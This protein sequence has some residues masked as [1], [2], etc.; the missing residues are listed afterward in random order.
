MEQ[1]RDSRTAVCAEH[2]S[3]S[4]A[5][6]ISGAVVTNE[7]HVAS[8]QVE[9]SIVSRSDVLGPLVSHGSHDQHT[10]D[11]PAGSI[12]PHPTGVTETIVVEDGVNQ[13]GS[14]DDPPLSGGTAP[15]PRAGAGNL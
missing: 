6:C 1:Q 3:T 10:R 15:P 5:T 11:V 14:S 7:L 12:P 9:A 8:S 4:A 2:S 13:A